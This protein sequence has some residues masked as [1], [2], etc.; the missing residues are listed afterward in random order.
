MAAFQVFE[1]SSYCI[2]PTIPWRLFKNRT[3]A[4]AFAIS[5]LHAML[6]LWVIY[7]L[8]I[9]FQAPLGSTASRPGVQLLPT[10]TT[11]LCF[12]SISGV[13]VTKTGR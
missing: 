12:A 7:I 6:T 4:S 11:L 1:G 9:Y 13:F 8:P 5:F 3:S 2:E 10:I